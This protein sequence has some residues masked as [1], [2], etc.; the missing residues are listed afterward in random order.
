MRGKKK[1]LKKTGVFFKDLLS[2]IDYE[3][4]FLFNMSVC[5]FRSISGINY[6]K[7][8]S[9]CFIL[10]L[11]GVNKNLSIYVYCST[12]EMKALLA[13]LSLFSSHI[14]TGHF[15]VYQ[16]TNNLLIFPINEQCDL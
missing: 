14:V 16:E 12:N 9:I 4:A 7:D 5:S 1:N 2:S 11:P 13:I 15:A 10:P 8:F 3:K 6:L